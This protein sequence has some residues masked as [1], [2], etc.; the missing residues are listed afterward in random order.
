MESVVAE[1]NDA[2]TMRE[3]DVDIS[4]PTARQTW[5]FTLRFVLSLI[6]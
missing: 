3:S 1:V 5:T 2:A 6:C 4:G